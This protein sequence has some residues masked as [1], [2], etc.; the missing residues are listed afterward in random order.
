VKVLQRISNFFISLKFI[1]C[2]NIEMPLERYKILPESILHNPEVLAVLSEANRNAIRGVQS[3]RIQPRSETK[4]AGIKI[5]K[6]AQTETKDVQTISTSTNGVSVTPGVEGTS[7]GT[8]TVSKLLPARKN[9]MGYTP[10]TD[11]EAQTDE[12]TSH[13]IAT[14]AS[15]GDNV[16]EDEV[17]GNVLFSPITSSS[18]KQNRINR[19]L[20]RHLNNFVPTKYQA[21]GDIVVPLVLKMINYEVNQDRAIALLNYILLDEDPNGMTPPPSW[22]RPYLTALLRARLSPN[23]FPVSKR[24]FFN[25]EFL[26]EF[27]HQPSRSVAEMNQSLASSRKRARVSNS[28]ALGSQRDRIIPEIT[29]E[30]TF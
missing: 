17:L 8:Q 30:Q 1:F 27:R 20:I 13:E 12:K 15:T 3:A 4:P 26:R 19:R 14:Q 16:D 29:I 25:E 28:Y 21:R 2:N 10:T 9:R 23:M 24:G 7:V 6:D 18:P 22:A 11:S 5:S